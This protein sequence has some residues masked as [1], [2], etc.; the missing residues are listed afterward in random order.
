MA[1]DDSAEMEQT[2][3]KWDKYVTNH[4]DHIEEQLEEER[5]WERDNAARNAEA[6]RTMK[7][8]VPPDIFHAD[9]Q[10]L[11]GRGLPP[12]LAKRVFDRKVG[13]HADNATWSREGAAVP[14]QWGCFF[15]PSFISP[16]THGSR[17]GRSTCSR[18][19]PE[20]Y[21]KM[22]TKYPLRLL[23]VVPIRL[24]PSTVY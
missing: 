5:K 3:D 19:Y 7:T 10:G 18:Y 4:P 1:G 20:R 15:I 2:L 14:W 17:R 23:R 6:L 9:L 13:D 12:V 21:N 16:H 24:L 22:A 11:R 8:F